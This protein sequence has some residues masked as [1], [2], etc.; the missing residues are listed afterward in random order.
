MQN[1]NGDTGEVYGC[2]GKGVRLYMRSGGSFVPKNLCV[3]MTK[4]RCADDPLTDGAT[5]V[6]ISVFL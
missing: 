5:Q 6:Y 1:L 2:I 4:S 3:L